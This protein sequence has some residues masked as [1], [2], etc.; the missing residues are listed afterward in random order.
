MRCHAVPPKSTAHK[1]KFKVKFLGADMA[2]KLTEKTVE[3]AKKG[4]T[5]W[6]ALATGLG[7][8]VTPKRKKIWVL[9]LAFPG[10]RSQS[11]R[12]IGRWPGMSLA[13]ARDKAEEWYNL[14]KQGSDP[15]EVERAKQEAAERERQEA[16][17]KAKREAR[18]TFEAIAED[19]IKGRTN[20]RAETDAREIRRTLVSEWGSK[21]I[22]SIAPRDVREYMT[23][24]VKAKP[25]EAK[26]AWGHADQIFKYAV[27]EELIEASPLASLNKKLVFKGAGIRSRDRVLDQDEIFALWRASARLKWPHGHRYRFLLLQG[28]RV[29][30]VQGSKWT[31]LHPELRRALRDAKAHPDKLAKL[32]ND[33]KLWTV[34]KERFKSDADHVVPLALLTIEL[35]STMPV[36]GEFMFSTS[37]K[38]KLWSNSLIKHE[39][40]RRMLRTLKAHARKRGDDAALVTLPRWV[41]HD[42]RRVV[43]TNLSALGVADNVAELAIGHGKHGL[44]RVYDM[45]KF[46]PE[47][48][49]ALDAWHEKLRE[50]IGST[51]PPSNVIPLR[52]RA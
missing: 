51:K 24:L 12:V 41:S 49:S 34:P 46:L 1:V 23:K 42:L 20:R 47:I 13:E 7:L 38:C 40:D 29:E 28:C 50:I 19:Y 43:R 22:A 36:R 3:N 15:V 32:T 26:N 52:R 4:T 10:Q 35:L 27:H 45:W 17:A 39:L 37:G 14:T 30:E 16:E 18:N 6:D 9:Q 21:P 5:T 25:Y 44:Q 48:R 2:V 31:E 8:K 33:Q 11:R